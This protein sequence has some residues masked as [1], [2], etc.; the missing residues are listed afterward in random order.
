MNKLI[1]G[2]AL[3]LVGCTST[4][5][6][7][8]DSTNKLVKAEQ[9]AADEIKHHPHFNDKG[10]LN[11]YNDDTFGDALKQNKFVLIECGRKA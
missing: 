9:V 10:T 8:T 2:L 5:S 4:R 6:I 7:E 11:W 1:I 3:L